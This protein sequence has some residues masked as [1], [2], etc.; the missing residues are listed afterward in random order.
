MSALS[1]FLMEGRCVLPL[2]LYHAFSTLLTLAASCMVSSL[3]VFLLDR[4]S[5]SSMEL[6]TSLILCSSIT[7]L[8]SGAALAW[9]AGYY[10]RPAKAVV[11]ATGL[12]A[13]GDFSIRVPPPGLA[14][15]RCRG[16]FPH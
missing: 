14:D 9:E 2:R 7:V 13:K 3:M 16:I 12:I 6:S 10:I 4:A 11:D 15:R 1:S 8:L 5:G